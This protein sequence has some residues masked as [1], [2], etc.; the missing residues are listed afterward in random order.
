MEEKLYKDKG[1]MHTPKI[2][3]NS[4]KIVESNKDKFRS[5]YSGMTE[6]KKRAA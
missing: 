6:A 1:W 5:I 4:K 3:K 2:N